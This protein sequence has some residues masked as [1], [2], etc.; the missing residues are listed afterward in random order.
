MSCQKELLV[1]SYIG[2]SLRH[3][4]TEEKNALHLIILG[5]C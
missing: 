3:L 2:K 1:I 5:H 4:K